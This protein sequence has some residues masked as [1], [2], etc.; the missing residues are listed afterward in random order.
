MSI[1]NTLFDKLAT[2]IET[3][4]YFLN[5]KEKIEKKYF[6]K[7]LKSDKDIFLTDKEFY[8]LLRYADILSRA[9]N[10]RFHNLSY[11][12]ICYMK[13]FYNT[14][15]YFNIISNII[16]VNIGNFPAKRLIDKD[17]ESEKDIEIYFVIL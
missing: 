11:N 15:H 7:I 1:S 5:L 8:D 9:N 12:I 2:K 13:E 10:E 14:N 17:G 3:D 6:Y 16:L 4:Y